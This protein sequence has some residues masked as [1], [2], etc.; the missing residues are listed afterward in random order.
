MR[1][2]GVVT[3]GRSDYG[4]YV[5]ILRAIQ[6]E[7]AL[8]LHLIV[9]GMH[10]LEEFGLTVREIEADRFP[11]GARVF[12][13]LPEDS[14]EAI[15]AAIGA[16]VT[17]FARA[18]ASQRPDLLIVLGDRFEMYAAAVAALPLK[19]PVAHIHGGELTQGA[20]DDALRHSLTKLSHLHFVATEEYAHRVIQLGEEPWRVTVSGAPSLDHVGMVPLLTAEALCNRFGWHWE[21]APLL[22]TYH[23]VTLEYEQTEWQMTELLD[24]LEECK[25]PMIFTMPNAD[26]HG[27]VIRR[28]LTAFI[29][30][31]PNAHAVEN[32]GTQG[33]FSLMAAAAAMIGNSSSG[34]IEAPSFGLPVVNI[35]TRQQG[36]VRASNVI[37]VGYSRTEII[38]GIRQALTAEF[39][40]AIRHGT[41]PYG[42][43]HAAT[44]IVNTLKAMPLDDRLIKKRFVDLP[45]ERPDRAD[46]PALVP[47]RGEPMERCVILGGGGHAR[48][49][50]DSL[51][52]SKLAVPYAVVDADR[53]LWGKELLG[54]PVVG[55]D[56]RLR[57]LRCEGVTRFIVGL[58]GVGDN[59][60]RQ[61]LFCLGMTSGL[62]PLTVCH[63]SAICSPSA[64]IGE[65]S[66]LAPATVVNSGAGLG[67]NV[68]VN[69]GA[70]VEHDCAIGDHVHLA[71]GAR[72]SGHV[73]VGA[74]AHIGAGATIRQRVTIGEG[75]IV[76]AGAV[77][78]KSVEPWTVVV[79]VPARVLEQEPADAH[80]KTHDRQHVSGRQQKEG[81]L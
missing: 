21:A 39:R 4:I 23:P 78:V 7:P 8:Q 12:L 11:I 32:L 44:V 5:P 10:L 67:V 31:H 62:A 26:M 15:A 40:A 57:E 58:G 25:R 41:N 33:Y 64:V 42:D 43:G 29:A 80:D 28:L 16:A 3:V 61:Q 52:A 14:P 75:A 30:S 65:G 24:A 22:V 20:M 54:V 45:V 76:G 47:T 48:V 27:R 71:T 1:T 6:H 79:G 73:L 36:R 18:Y 37:D 66:F 34:L 77:V 72:L 38:R 9:S 51:L 19:I 70:I 74:G 13:P 35:G 46:S 56:E 63:P 55:D 49:V 17:G 60:P 2:I 68:I 59:G 53:S 81:A 50:I 69:T